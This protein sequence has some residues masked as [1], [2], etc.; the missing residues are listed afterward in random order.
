[1][2]PEYSEEY[3]ADYEEGIARNDPNYPDVDWFNA[4]ATNNGLMT[5]NFITISQG[6]SK[7]KSLTKLGYLSQNGITENTNYKKY[8]LRS[9][10]DYQASENL[11]FQSDISLLF[12]EAKEP[13]KL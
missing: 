4:T 9:N 3:I 1:M 10:N 6:T 12:T 13:T 5:N 7:I 2:T 8:T 11:S